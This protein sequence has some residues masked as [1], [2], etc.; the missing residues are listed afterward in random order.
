MNKS[1][2]LLAIALL[3]LRAQAADDTFDFFKEEAQVI[4]ASRRPEAIQRVPVSI[5]VVTSADIAAYGFKNIWDALRYRA[6]V[7][8][9]VARFRSVPNT[10]AELT[11]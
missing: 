11:P 6:G 1:L 4:T 10:A 5:D 3:P 2:P 7:D 8:V 9:R